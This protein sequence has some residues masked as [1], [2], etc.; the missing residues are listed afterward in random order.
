[1][2]FLPVWAQHIAFA[3]PF[4]QVLQD[5]RAAVVPQREAVTVSVVYG[6]QFARVLPLT[7]LALLLVAA[8]L[9][10]KHDEPYLAELT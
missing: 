6:S 4:V 3:N 7:V 2:G 9:I 5:I 8:W 1:M 10:F